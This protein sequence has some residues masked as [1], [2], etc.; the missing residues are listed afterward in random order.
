M[1]SV[2]APSRILVFQDL[3]LPAFALPV[4]QVGLKSSSFFFQFLAV[5]ASVVFTTGY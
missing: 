1:Q 5:S 2:S 4:L 3:N